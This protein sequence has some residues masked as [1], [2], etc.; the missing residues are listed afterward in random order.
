[1][2]LISIFLKYYSHVIFH[3]AL[4]FTGWVAWTFAE[5]MALR[6]L[7]HSA[8]KENQVIDF[9]HAWHH[10]HPIEIKFRAYNDAY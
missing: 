2:I 6:Y 1:M 4:F 10:S 5:Y 7:M 3:V 9:N 8:G